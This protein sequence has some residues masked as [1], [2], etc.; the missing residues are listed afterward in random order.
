MRSS[1]LL[2]VTHLALILFYRLLKL[3]PSPFVATVT[4]RPLLLSCQPPWRRCCHGYCAARQI[5]WCLVLLPC[6]VAAPRNPH[7]LQMETLV[8]QVVRLTRFSDT[9]PGSKTVCVSSHTGAAAAVLILP[10]AGK[11]AAKPRL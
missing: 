5:S 11:V 7:P 9:S 6:R 10:S 1:S 2:S 3:L 4:S 8:W